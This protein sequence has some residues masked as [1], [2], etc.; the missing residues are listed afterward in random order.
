MLCC[1]SLLHRHTIQ[2]ATNELANKTTLLLKEMSSLCGGS[3]PTAV[4]SLKFK[5]CWHSGNAAYICGQSLSLLCQGNAMVDP[6]V[7][8]SG[9]GGGGAS[10]S[11]FWE[12]VS[13]N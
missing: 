11:S 6:N 10:F 12:F 4:S 9:G 8:L 3:S 7:E 13:Q 1:I 5:V 2:Q